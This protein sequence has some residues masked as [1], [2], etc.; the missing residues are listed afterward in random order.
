M[1]SVDQAVVELLGVL[2]V[3]V[4]VSVCVLRFRVSVCYGLGLGFRVGVC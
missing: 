1:Q 4:C 3:R 2:C